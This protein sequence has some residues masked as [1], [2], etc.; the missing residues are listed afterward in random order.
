MTYTGPFRINLSYLV[1]PGEISSENSCRNSD[2]Y[3]G[4]RYIVMMMSTDDSALISRARYSND[5]NSP[6]S[7]S[8]HTHTHTHTHT[9]FDLNGTMEQKEC[10]NTMPILLIIRALQS[11]TNS[12]CERDT[13]P[14]V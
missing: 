6:R 5:V 1:I 3:F 9:P 4:G 10:E 13:P 7:M 2:E 12:L 8:L 14:H 11:Q